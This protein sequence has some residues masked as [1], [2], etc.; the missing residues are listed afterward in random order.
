MN[1]RQRSYQLCAGR[2]KMISLTWED[3]QQTTATAESNDQR[4]SYMCVGY[5]SKQVSV[6]CPITGMTLA[7]FSPSTGVL[8]FVDGRRY[9]LK[10]AY[11]LCAEMLW[12]DE[13]GRTVVRFNGDFGTNDK[14]G[15]VELADYPS[16]SLSEEAPMLVSLGWYLMISSYVDMTLVL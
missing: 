3:A 2:K 7:A 4:W 15:S 1:S 10:C 12:E 16:F 13:Y 14:S 5:L 9:T 11:P 6:R 8:R